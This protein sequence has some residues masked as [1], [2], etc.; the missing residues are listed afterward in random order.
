MPQFYENKTPPDIFSWKFSKNFRTVTFI[1]T[2]AYKFTGIF[3]YFLPSSHTCILGEVGQPILKVNFAIEGSDGHAMQYD[4][5]GR[6]IVSQFSRQ[7]IY[8]F[9]L[10]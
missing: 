3:S 7:L 9:M 10:S 8:F 4:F 6:G 2:A 5:M 1:R